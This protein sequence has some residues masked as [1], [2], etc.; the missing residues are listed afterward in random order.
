MTDPITKPGLYGHLTNEQYHKDPVPEGSLSQSGA[1]TLTTYTPAHFKYE[2]DHG[3]PP[4]RA[5]DVGQAAHD[6]VLE[7]SEDNLVVINATSYRTK[8]AQEAQ[9]EAYANGKTPLLIAELETVRAMAKVIREHPVAG[10]LFDPE[11]GGLPEQSGFWRDPETDV[12]CRARFDWLP[13]PDPDRR[14]IVP[15]YKTSTTADP[16]AWRKK[17]ADFGYHVQDWWYCDAV[18]QL[19]IHEHPSFVFVVQEKEPPYLL[20]VV[21]LDADA[22]AVGRDQ[23]MRARALYADCVR[24]DHWPGY[25]EDVEQ[26]ALPAW[27]LREHRGA[28]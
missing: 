23:A 8:A 10:V 11:R 27:Y 20:S 15:D 21:Q 6:L 12:W 13:E 3:R 18:R 9:A 26:V 2:R 24:D 28:A 19:G 16:N 17:A 25:S 22:V 14:F 7:R 5:F 4:K 1:K